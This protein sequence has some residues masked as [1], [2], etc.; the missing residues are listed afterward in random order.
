MFSECHKKDILSLA[1]SRRFKIAITGDS[2]GAL[3]VWDCVLG[4][5]K[6]CLSNTEGDYTCCDQTNPDRSVEK[7]ISQCCLLNI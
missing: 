1:F 3:M 7:V 2:D 4:Q 6:K 5:F